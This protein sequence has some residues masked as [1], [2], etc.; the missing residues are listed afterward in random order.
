MGKKE[1][2][3]QL[4][5]ERAAIIFNQKGYAGTSMHDIIA[6]TGLTKGGIYGNFK[7]KKEI[8]I[9]AFEY[10]VAHV[11]QQVRKRSSQYTSAIDKLRAA[12]DFY[13]E[14]LVNAPIEGGCPILNMS[15]EVDDTNP[16]LRSRVVKAMDDWQYSIK[17][18]VEKGIQRGEIQPS[19]SPEDFAIF[20]VAAIEGGILLSRAHDSEKHLHIMLN[21][22]EQTI[23]TELVMAH[24]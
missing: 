14:Y 11:T 12:I 6:A 10:A 23:R 21:Q 1:Q 15:P 20:F 2:T 18:V 19:V 13:R 8:A 22:L 16:E 4:I 7:S 24:D 5:I 3:R 17:R 9:A